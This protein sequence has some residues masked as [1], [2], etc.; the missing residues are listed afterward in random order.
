[1]TIILF[2]MPASAAAGKKPLRTEISYP[3][4]PLNNVILVSFRCV[5]YFGNVVPMAYSRDHVGF[6]DLFHKQ[7]VHSSNSLALFPGSAQVSVPC[8]AMKQ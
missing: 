1:M 3:F 2:G 6:V 7:Y 8:S 4:P 5:P